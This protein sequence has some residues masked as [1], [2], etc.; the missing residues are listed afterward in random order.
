MTDT[1][2]AVSNQSDHEQLKEKSKNKNTLKAT[3]TWWKFG[4]IGQQNGKLTRMLKSAKRS[5]K[6]CKLVFYAEIR[7]LS[8]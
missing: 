6:C 1:C 8:I 7:L 5:I 4:R 3:Q 2:F